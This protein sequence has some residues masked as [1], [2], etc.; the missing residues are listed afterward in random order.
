MGTVTTKTTNT[1]ASKVVNGI[2]SKDSEVGSST[3]RLVSEIESSSNPGS[4][5][6]SSTGYQKVGGHEP[7]RMSQSM[8][9]SAPKQRRRRGDRSGDTKKSNASSVMINAKKLQSTED[10]AAAM[11]LQAN[12]MLN[13][14]ASA[15]AK[16]NL[17][18][19]AKQIMLE[20]NNQANQDEQTVTTAASSAVNPSKMSIEPLG[21]TNSNGNGSPQNTKSDSVLNEL[22]SENGG[23]ASEVASSAASGSARRLS[24]KD[25]QERKSSAKQVGSGSEEKTAAIAKSKTLGKDSFGAKNPASQ[26]D[27]QGF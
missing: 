25:R 17:I 21:E 12:S 27:K 2:Q 26:E 20:L 11:S 3:K 13:Q 24:R 8:V 10:A 9:E 22:I 7:I 23:C 15:P 1:L 19:Q 6:A 4:F 18:E 14:N 5:V 16:P